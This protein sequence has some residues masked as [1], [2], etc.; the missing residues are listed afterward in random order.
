[1]KPQKGQCL[2]LNYKNKTSAS[3]RI[4]IFTYQTKLATPAPRLKENPLEGGAHI[5]A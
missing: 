5:D 1:M 2:E 4:F 3:R